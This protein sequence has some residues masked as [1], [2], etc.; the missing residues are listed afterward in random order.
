MTVAATTSTTTTTASTASS[1][2]VTSAI[3]SQ[4]FLN[5]LVTELQNQ[6]PLDPTNSTDFI[7]QL[8]SYANFDQQQTLNSNMGTLVSSLNSLLT[9]NS[10]NYIGQTV[11]AKTD[12]GT[13]KDGQISFGYSLESAASDVTLSVKDSSGNTVWTGSGTTTSGTNSFTW[14]GTATDGTQLTDGGQYTLNVSATDSTGQSV[15]GY[16]TVT[17][18]VTSIDNSSGTPMLNIGSTSVSTSNV[19]GVTS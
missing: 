12:T 9:L 2:S 1:S 8:T 5:L 13:L 6:N 19:I 14:D 11:T 16:T 4:Q 7:N 18:K 3:T 10:S 15:Y 17:G